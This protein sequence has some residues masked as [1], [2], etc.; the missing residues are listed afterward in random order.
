M[1]NIETLHLMLAKMIKED[2]L[3]CTVSAVAGHFVGLILHATGTEEDDIG[4]IYIDGGLSRD[5]TVHGAKIWTGEM[6]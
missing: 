6:Q 4:E 1:T 5:I 2:G 3:D